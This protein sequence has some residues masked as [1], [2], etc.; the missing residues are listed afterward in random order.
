MRTPRSLPPVVRKL[1]PWLAGWLTFQAALAVAGRLVA[2]RK[3]VGDESSTSIRKVVAQGGLELRPRNPQLSRVRL[4]LVMAGCRLDLTAIPRP[5]AGIDLTVRA[6]MAGLAVVVPPDWRV[7]WEFRG[8]GGIDTDG[9]LQRTHDE[10]AADLR[11][12]AV[13][14]LGGIGVEAG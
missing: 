2:R 5:P 9:G 1:L 6:T 3:N 12:H 13:V 14:A 4:D 8:A 7:W 10:H 11:V